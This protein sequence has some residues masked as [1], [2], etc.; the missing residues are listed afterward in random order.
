MR[1]RLEDAGGFVGR[2]CSACH[3][4]RLLGRVRLPC[5]CTG[6]LGG[7]GRFGYARDALGLGHWIAAAQL[8]MCLTLESSALA[9][10]VIP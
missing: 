3:A 2:S 5:P 1:M 6:S 4:S 9:A 8:A 10:D 7:A